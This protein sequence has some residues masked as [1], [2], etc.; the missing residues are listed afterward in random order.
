MSRAQIIYIV[1]SSSIIAIILIIFSKVKK[2]NRWYY[3]INDL[4]IYLSNKKK[5]DNEI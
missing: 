3:S 5:L 1:C 2:E 4:F